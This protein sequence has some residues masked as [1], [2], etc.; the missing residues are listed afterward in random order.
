MYGKERSITN[1][2]CICLSASQEKPLQADRQAT[3]QR[4]CP[5]SLGILHKQRFLRYRCIKSLA[6]SSDLRADPV[7]SKRFNFGP[8]EVLSNLSCP[9][10]I[11]MRISQ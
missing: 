3:G 7:L 6:A 4:G 11:D 10:H 9:V 5:E 2:T 1:S 8:P